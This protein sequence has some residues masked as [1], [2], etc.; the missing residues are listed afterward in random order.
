MFQA[1][2]NRFRNFDFDHELCLL[3][4]VWLFMMH[5]SHAGCDG[6]TKFE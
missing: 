3:V 6:D 1:D 4:C 2:A 5:S